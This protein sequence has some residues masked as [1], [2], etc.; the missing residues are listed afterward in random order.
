MFHAPEPTPVGK[1][2]GHRITELIGP[3][4]GPSRGTMATQIS[5]EEYNQHRGD[6]D[7][8]CLSCREWTTGGV[9]PDAE[10]YECEACGEPQVMGVETALV[11]GEVEVA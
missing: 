2:V 3:A 11:T 1:R 4:H 7:G 8:L 10:E 6:Y 9:E 5:M